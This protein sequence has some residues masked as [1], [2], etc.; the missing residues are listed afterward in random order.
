MFH[1]DDKTQGFQTYIH[2]QDLTYIQTC[3]S[4]SSNIHTYTFAPLRLQTYIH[5]RLESK[6]TYIHTCLERR[7]PPGS[8]PGCASNSLRTASKTKRLIRFFRIARVGTSR[9]P[10]GVQTCMYV[11]MYVCMFELPDVHV[12]MYV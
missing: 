4:G 7:S 10:E 11:C 6:Q 5:T 2:S 9:S 3:T 8:H 12:C 1:F